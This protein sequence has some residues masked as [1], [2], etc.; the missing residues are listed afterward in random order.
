MIIALRYKTKARENCLLLSLFVYTELGPLDPDWFDVL[1][2]Q[3][4]PNEGNVSDL[5]ELSPNQEGRFKTPFDTPA[6]DCQ[7]FST[8][9]DFR[10]NRVVSPEAGDDRSF[11]HGQGDNR[12][13]FDC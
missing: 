7:L 13:K 9:R 2:C 10:P 1:T 4:F 6:V 3:T 8:P 11:T 12:F 5:R